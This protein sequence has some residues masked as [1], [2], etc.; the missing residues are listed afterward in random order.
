[1]CMKENM[2][3]TYKC[4]P[5]CHT[6]P[7]QS[8]VVDKTPTLEPVA[9]THW[10][11]PKTMQPGF[12]IKFKSFSTRVFASN[13]YVMWWTFGRAALHLFAEL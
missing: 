12:V 8:S 10:L 13:D 2:L 7:D 3:T 9:R 1:M 5:F 11:L 4:P 6:M